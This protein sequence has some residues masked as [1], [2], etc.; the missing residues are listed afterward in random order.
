M[1]RPTIP[2]SLEIPAIRRVI[3]QREVRIVY[4]PVVD[5]RSGS[6]FAYEA[7]VR[8]SA[9]EFTSPPLLFDAAVK[10]GCT[11][12]LGR[13]LRKLS[14]ENCPDDRLFINIHPAELD[15][16]YLVRPDDPLYHH[17]EEVYLEI[18]EGVPL[19]HFALCRTILEE[20]RGRGVHLVVDDLGAGYSNLKYIADLHPRVVKLDRD[21]IAGLVEDTRLFK[22]VSA[23]VVL[24]NSLDALVVAEG[25][26]TLPELQAVKAA[27]AHFGQGYLLARPAFP[28]PE[29]NW[30]AE[31]EEFEDKKTKMRTG[32]DR[33][34]SRQIGRVKPKA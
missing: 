31:V 7:L 34:G 29:V 33:R 10:Y 9:P 2:P 5:L 4:Q 16:G 15:E 24:C 18:T 22:L 30:P 17:A 26:E 21:L 20:V 32:K 1:K 14:V 28:L 27:G 8:S 23:I 13:L 19:S 25:I 3:E 12:E 11:G 6:T